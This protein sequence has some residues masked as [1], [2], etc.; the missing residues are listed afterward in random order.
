MKI[1]SDPLSHWKEEGR[2]YLALGFVTE[3]KPILGTKTA[4]SEAA[5]SARRT[6]LQVIW[7]IDWSFTVLITFTN[8]CFVSLDMTVMIM[9]LNKEK[10]VIHPCAILSKFAPTQNL[11][12]I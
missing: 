12:K 4:Y 8:A 3:M 1:P 10:I 5:T 11:N 6:H 9:L 2:S 7:S